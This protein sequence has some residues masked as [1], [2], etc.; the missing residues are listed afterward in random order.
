LWLVDVDA[1]GRETRRGPYAV[2]QSYGARPDT[3]KYD[4]TQAMIDVTRNRASGSSD[5]AYLTVSD[6]GMHRVTYEALVAAG[7]NLAGVPSGEIALL[8]R[9]G[10]VS[11]AVRGPAVFGPGSVVE[12]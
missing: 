6:A 9:S 8:S 5:A 3:R 2:G 11:R 10:P 1:Q 7:V 12:F 4:W